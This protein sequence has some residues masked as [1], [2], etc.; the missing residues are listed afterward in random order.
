MIKDKHICCL[1]GKEFEGYGNNPAPYP[2]DICCDDCNEIAVIT[3]RQFLA[4]MI[5]GALIIHSNDAV[6]IRVPKNKE[7]NKFTLEELQD[8][9]GG[10]VE[11]HP[12]TPITAKYD[13]LI[14]MINEEGLLYHMNPNT[15]AWQMFSLQIVGPLVIVSKDCLEDD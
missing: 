1:C 10:Y 6:S 7:T 14:F 12:L 8:M 5:K 2:G 11:H 15:L 4:G 9:V 3:T 13:G